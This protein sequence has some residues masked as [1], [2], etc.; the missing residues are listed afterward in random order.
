MRIWDEEENPLWLFTV[1][2]FNQIPDGTTLESIGSDYKIKGNDT[3]DMDVRGRHIAWGVRD[4]MN[5][6]LKNLF[7]LFLL[8]Q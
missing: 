3:I 2:E 4:P 8:K 5:H 7:T 6:E 1:D